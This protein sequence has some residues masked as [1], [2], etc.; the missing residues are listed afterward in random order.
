MQLFNFVL[1]TMSIAKDYAAFSLLA[2]EIMLMRAFL[3]AKTHHRVSCCFLHWKHGDD[4]LLAHCISCMFISAALAPRA[5][6]FWLNFQ[7][8]FVSIMMPLAPE[9]AKG[10][11]EWTVVYPTSLAGKTTEARNM[12]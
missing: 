7:E 8:A 3:V 10:E 11:S 12:F 1:I 9:S 2:C 6:Y 4:F 5:I